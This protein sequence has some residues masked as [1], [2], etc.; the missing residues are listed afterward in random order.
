MKQRLT[1]EESV[2][3]LRAQPEKQEL[4]RACYYDDPV[5]AALERFESSDEFQETRR[6]L[7]PLAGLRVL[8]LGAGRGIASYGFARA[9]AVV[10]A[11]EPDPS[12]VV[13]A[14][15]I[16]A[17]TR[18]LHLPVDVVTQW[19]EQLPF[20]NA[21]FDVVYARA[22]LHH[23]RQLESL[24]SEVARVLR[25]SGSFL[26]VREHVVRTPKEH[27]A[28]LH[29]HP[30]HALYGGENAYPLRRYLD[31]LE[32]AGLTVDLLLGPHDSVVNFAP[33]VAAE[34]DRALLGRLGRSS[35]GAALLVLPG[36]RK[37]ARA[38]RSLLDRTPGRHFSFL[39]KPR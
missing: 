34:H 33:A 24:C 13:G 20:A 39:T 28:F 32:G 4:V 26:A 38:L 23:A 7:P 30:L 3:W 8:D 9:G 21:S 6:L 5:E 19:G 14:A 16:Q 2:C 1:W 18:K 37:T 17:W 10:T 29:N 11:L 36:V 35:L 31:A 12:G 25:P 15:A 22:V 27:Q